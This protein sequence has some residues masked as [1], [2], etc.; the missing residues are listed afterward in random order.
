MIKE[1]FLYQKIPIDIMNDQIN[2][3]LPENLLLTAKKYAEAHGYSTIQEL[4]KESLREKI[5]R[6]D[7][8]KKEL[9]L[10]KALIRVSDEKILYGSEDNLFRKLGKKKV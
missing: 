4:I 2:L 7:V 5:F 3:R 6:Q 1:K 10:I 8:S 9:S